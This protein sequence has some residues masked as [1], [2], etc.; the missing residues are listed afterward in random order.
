M[1]D[2]DRQAIERILQ[3]IERHANVTDLLRCAI[4]DIRG[5]I[6]TDDVPITDGTDERERI[7]G[8]ILNGTH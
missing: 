6:G 7:L 3:R 1:N 8:E 5:I 2:Q 4:F